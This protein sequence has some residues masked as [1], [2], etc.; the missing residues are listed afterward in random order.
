M[1]IIVRKDLNQELANYGL[2]A[3]HGLLSVHVNKVLPEHSH[4]HLFTYCFQATMAELSSCVRDH[5]AFKTSN[6]CCLVLY[7][8]GLLTP[9]LSHCLLKYLPISPTSVGY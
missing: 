2:W 3:K 5:M 9:D 4:A 6:I 1:A 8:K 7:R